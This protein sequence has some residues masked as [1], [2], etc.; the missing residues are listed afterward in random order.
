MVLKLDPRHPLVW[1]SPSSL[2]LGVDPALVTM[3]DVSET[4]ERLLAA[5]VAGVGL[6][7]LTMLARGRLE[8]RDELLR[9]VQPVLL[10][11]HEAERTAA[12]VAVL[13]HRSHGGGDRGDPAR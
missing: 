13:G 4:S 7:G 12:I 1:R 8:E 3:H 10:P 5:L 2:Q 6:P 9:L 11:E